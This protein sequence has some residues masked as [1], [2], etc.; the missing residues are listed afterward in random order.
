MASIGEPISGI[1][2]PKP[3]IG[4]NQCPPELLFII[5][6]L[7]PR[8]RDVYSFACIDRATW[9]AAKQE[10]VI[11]DILFWKDY[12]PRHFTQILEKRR[13]SDPDGGLQRTVELLQSCT[14][15]LP[16]EAE[17]GLGDFLVKSQGLGPRVLH[18][19]ALHW[20]IHYGLIQR[21]MQTITLTKRRWPLYI[22]VPSPD[23][24]L[25]IHIA[26]LRGQTA[27]VE[28]LLNQ[29]ICYHSFPALSLNHQR[30]VTMTFDYQVHHSGLI[31]DALGI[32][33][34]SQQSDMFELL[35]ERFPA[36]HYHGKTDSNTKV[37]HRGV[38][39]LHLAIIL[40]LPDTIKDLLAR[41]FKLDFQERL[42][43]VVL[44]T[45][46]EWT[47]GVSEVIRRYC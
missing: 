28:H 39:P 45:K 12:L 31:L 20:F 46:L 3:T 30:F 37:F 42:L 8:L 19:S 14:T 24:L 38:Y 34:A 10:M 27:V 40:A 16:K 35:I 13:A 22:N 4:L 17:D 9:W 1:H 5:A 6:K 25:P 41:G 33:I 44:P 47:A 11:R 32:A 21:A 36:E 2:Q 26:T 18:T 43:G 7:L 29:K 15:E 23:G